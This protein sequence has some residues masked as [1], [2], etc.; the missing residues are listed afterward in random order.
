MHTEAPQ[1]REGVGPLSAPGITLS[2]TGNGGEVAPEPGCCAP[3]KDLRGRT[4]WEGSVETPPEHCLHLSLFSQQFYRVGDTVPITAEER[5]A[6]AAVRGLL[7]KPQQDGGKPGSQMSVSDFKI[8]PNSPHQHSGGSSVPT[9]TLSTFGNVPSS[10]SPAWE[11]LSPPAC[12]CREV[13]MP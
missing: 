1:F 7:P 13:E 5:R 9:F 6:P 11:T 10:M 4:L 8:Q 12:E 3:S 2:S